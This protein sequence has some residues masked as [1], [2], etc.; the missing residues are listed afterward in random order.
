MTLIDSPNQNK[1][2]IFCS[3]GCHFLQSLKRSQ[4]WNS[5]AA[6]LVK[7]VYVI[8]SHLSSRLSGISLLLPK[9]VIL[10]RFTNNVMK[11][12]SSQ[13]ALMTRQL[14]F[15]VQCVHVFSNDSL[16][17]SLSQQVIQFLLDVMTLVC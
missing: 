15:Q 2:Q 3:T 14:M 16:L 6:D 12:R 17:M 1:S 4:L 8:S 10:G 5:Y 11:E 13:S 9:S 7:C